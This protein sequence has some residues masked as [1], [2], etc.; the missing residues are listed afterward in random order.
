MENQD[1]VSTANNTT[2]TAAEDDND[3]TTTTATTATTT[4]IS[5]SMQL[6][7]SSVQSQQIPVSVFSNS[8]TTIVAAA[9]AAK[10]TPTLSSSSLSSTIALKPSA[11]GDVAAFLRAIQAAR[12]EGFVPRENVV[13]AFFKNM[14]PDGADGKLKTLLHNPS[15][16]VVVEDSSPNRLLW[17][18]VDGSAYNDVEAQRWDGID[19]NIARSYD[20]LIDRA[21]MD[22]LWAWMQ[23]S[24]SLLRTMNEHPRSNQIAQ[25]RFIIDRMIKSG[26]L[27]GPPEFM[28]KLKPAQAVIVMY[29]VY[30]KMTK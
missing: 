19:V 24:E 27:S 21:Q 4:I 2:S 29:N 11:A 9:A 3:T 17:P 12:E 8:G 15:S 16:F 18:F 6:D 25:L 26:T 5:N 10:S 20:S 22:T 28:N 7:Q 14:Y 1:N 13:R 30:S 23:K